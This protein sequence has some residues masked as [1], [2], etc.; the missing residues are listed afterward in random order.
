MKFQTLLLMVLFFVTK[1]FGEPLLVVMLMVKNEEQVIEATLKPY[2][3]AGIQS[4]LIFDT[5]STD[6]TLPI[7]KEY[8]KAHDI[9]AGCIEQEPFIDFATSRNRA[10]ELAQQKFPHATF[11]LMPDAEWYM[12][13]V[14]GLLQF[15]NEHKDAADASYFIPI[16]NDIVAFRVSRLIRCR[17]DIQFVGL[18]HEVLNKLTH[19][20]LPEDIY[21][22]W[23]PTETG[24]EKSA[25]RWQRDRD[26]LV[27][28]YAQNP[29]DV[30]TLFYLAQ[31]Y[32]CLGDLENA[33]RFYKKRADIY[34]W[35]E[36][37]F[38][39]RLRLGD[40]AQ[41]LA[42][43]DPRTVCP[44]AIKHYLE[45]FALRPHRAEPLVKIAQYYID[46]NQMHLAFLFAA[47]AVQIPY[48]AHDVLFVE[49]YMYDFVRY[50]LLGRCAWY[51]GEYELGE[52]AIKQ[53]LEVHPQAEH[54]HH[55][56]KF[57]TGRRSLIQP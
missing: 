56:L 16:R 18:V 10:L 45:A 2:V 52:W 39:T 12:H 5:G 19:S 42:S 20:T 24:K 50:D 3:D 27:K 6:N 47:R 51:V 21:F 25:Q 11:M 22:E 38:M 14:E 30:R 48:P 53:A 31:T 34:G 54:L 8:F 13:N 4:F 43:K 57:Y 17:A 46:N 44:L 40:V 36:E 55:N 49:K 37:N 23:R 32:E 35:D 9:Q 15:C 29:S 26:L 41:Q 1:V 7:V 33:Y 28:S